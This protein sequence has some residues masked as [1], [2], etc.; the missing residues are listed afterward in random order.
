MM[1]ALSCARQALRSPHISFG[2]PEGKGLR[3]LGPARDFIYMRSP[4]VRFLAPDHTY[5][6]IP[7]PGLGDNASL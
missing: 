2:T 5:P 3:E 7:Y 6:E 1:L 4:Q